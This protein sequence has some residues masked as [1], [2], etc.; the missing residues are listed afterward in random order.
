MIINDDGL[1][2]NLADVETS[3][4]LKSQ[5]NDNQVVFKGVCFHS[6]GWWL[7]RFVGKSFGRSML[8]NIKTGNKW[9]AEPFPHS[10]YNLIDLYGVQ[11]SEEQNILGVVDPEYMINGSRNSDFGWDGSNMNGL[12]SDEDMA[13]LKAVKPDDNPIIVLFKLKDDI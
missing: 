2:L 3:F 13:K 8:Y 12:I 1:L 6:N 5:I 9:F 10:F 7:Y 11:D 4:D